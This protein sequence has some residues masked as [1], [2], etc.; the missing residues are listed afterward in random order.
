[1]PKKKYD[2][3]FMVPDD[4]MP[5]EGFVK[6][7]IKTW[8]KIEDMRKICLTTYISKAREGKACWTKFEPVQYRDYWLTQWTDMCFMC[9][10]RFFTTLGKIPYS[11]LNWDKRPRLGSG[12]GASISSFMYRNG[13]NI[14]QVRNSL[15][16]PQP[17]AHHSKMNPWRVINDPINQPVL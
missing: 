1:M 11:R 10:Q 14:C 7:A 17:E 5:V 13:W 3:Y 16:T 4:F 6:K 12:V 2:Y 9:E 8:K 15:F